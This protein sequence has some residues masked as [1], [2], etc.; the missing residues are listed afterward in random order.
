MQINPLILRPA[1][2][3]GNGDTNFITSRAVL[4]AVYKKMKKKMNLLWGSGLKLSSVHVEDLCKAVFM[5]RDQEGVFNVAD[6]NDTT[7]D[8]INRILKRLIGNN[9]GY[10]SR[11][12]SNFADL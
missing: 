11:T 10:Y 2:V 5:L 8:H 9:F 3:Y 6:L 7:Q 1:L 4:A 12:I